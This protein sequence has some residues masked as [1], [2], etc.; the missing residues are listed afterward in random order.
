MSGERQPIA[1]LDPRFSSPDAT[2]TP[3]AA[4]RR[5]LQESEI[6]WLSTVRP[7]GRPHVTPLIAVWLD[8][9]PCF[10]TGPTERKAKNLAANPSCILT[11]GTNRLDEGLDVVAE[12]EAVPIT[13]EG[14]LQ[15]VVDAFAAK[16]PEP[17]HFKLVDGRLGGDGGEILAFRIRMRKAFG[18]GREGTYS[19]TRWRFGEG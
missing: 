16:Y 5:R 8:D 3:W 12:G 14:A 6:F 7:D 19:Q 18:F 9:S 10:T 1:E 4:G 15:R 2:P 17:F 13:D 11:T